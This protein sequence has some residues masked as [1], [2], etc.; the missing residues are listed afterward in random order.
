DLEKVAHD[1][2]AKIWKWIGL[3]VCVGIG[4][5][6]TEAKISN[7]IAKKNQGFKGVCDLVNMDPC[8]K[9]YYFDQIDVSEVWGVGRKHAKKLHTMGV[10]TVLDLAC[11]EAREMQ[12]QFSIVMSRTINE[13][14]GISCIEI[15]DT[16]PSKKQIIKS[17]SF[18]TKVTE[19]S[20]LKEAIAMHAQEACKRL[21]DEESLC[22][23]LLVFVQS[24]PFDESAPFYNKSI[25]GSFSQPTDCALDFVKAAVK[26]VADI[27]KEGI[28]YKKC[29]VIL[30][31]LEPKSGHTY[32]LLT[33]FEIID[34]KEQLMKTLDNVHTKFG[35]KKLGISTC[36]VPGRNWSMSR[37]KLSR[38]PFLWDELLTINN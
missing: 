38:N 23:C 3:P 22:G 2:R 1:M 9:E 27:F 24:S 28:K 29:G 25:T 8:N 20:D 32:D 18:G 19:L 33:D 13:L 37:D 21:R 17:C 4:R 16:P 12:R 31:G 11:T 35:K 34:K 30:T 36:Y 7:H 15:E 14:Q 5:S 10:K 6:K 26:M